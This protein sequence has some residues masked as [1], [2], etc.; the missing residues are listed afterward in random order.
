MQMKRIK[1]YVLVVIMVLCIGKIASAEGACLENNKNSVVQVVMTY[2]GQDGKRYTVQSGSGVVLNSN[3]VLTNYHVVHM[4]ESNIKKAVKYITKQGSTADI[5]SDEN[6]QIAIVKQDD[7]LITASIAQE[8]KDN[9]FAILNLEEETDRPA[10]VMCKEDVTVVAQTVFAAGYPTT[11]PFSKEGAVFFKPTDINLVSG[12]V[13]EVND[14]S[15]KISGIISGGNSG[16]VL[17]DAV[18]GEM[19]GLLVYSKKDAEKECFKAI[20]VN[21]IKHPYLDGITYTENTVEQPEATEEMTEEPEETVTVDKASLEETIQKA[22]NLDQSAYTKETYDFM[23]TWLTQAQSVNAKEDATQ[24]EVDFAT[25]NLQKS[26]GNLVAEKKISGAVIACIVIAA[27]AVS[28]VIVLLIVLL[29]R[30]NKQKREQKKF[31]VLP[32]KEGAQ[33]KRPGAAYPVGQQQAASSAQFSGMA[34]ADNAT[35]LLNMAGMDSGNPANNATTV[36]NASPVPQVK[37][38]LTRRKNGDVRCIDGIE[39][40]VGKEEA[41]VHFYIGDNEA[42]SR[43]HMKIIKRGAG[44]VVKDLGATNFT[45]LNGEYIAPQEERPLK[46]GDLIMAADEE[47][48]FEIK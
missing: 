41:K 28:A 3:T 21:A 14:Q 9:D 47:F 34:G 20:P 42:V 29:V 18:S 22:V 11:K 17:L 10:V 23:I 36:L 19:I 40:V 12:V 38:Y 48:V 43:C 16:G 44:Y 1:T 6:M 46:N 2:T 31:T 27:I 32:E 37:A 26:M 25:D 24:D 4:T 35:T 5:S 13:S 39:F 45:Y 33:F 8:S 7:V 30:M 15:V